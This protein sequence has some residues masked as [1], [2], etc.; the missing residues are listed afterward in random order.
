MRSSRKVVIGNSSVELGLFPDTE[1]RAALADKTRAYER[2]FDFE[3]QVCRKDGV[4][5][6]GLS[7]PT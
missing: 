3:V 5:L 6:H 1:Q 2:I 7:R 4:I